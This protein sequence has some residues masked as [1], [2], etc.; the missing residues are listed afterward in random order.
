MRE[1]IDNFRNMAAIKDRCRQAGNTDLAHFHGSTDEGAI[2]L[3]DFFIGMPVPLAKE[4]SA[5]TPTH[6]P[7]AKLFILNNF[8]SDTNM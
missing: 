4:P 2:R 5:S 3:K 7:R 8:L 6:H 1:K